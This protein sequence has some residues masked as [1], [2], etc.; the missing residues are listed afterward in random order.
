[1]QS[2][3]SL[4]FQKFEFNASVYYLVREI[5]F[6]VKGYNIIQVAGS[7]LAVFTF[8]AILL[9]A[10]YSHRSMS[11]AKAML[12]ALVIYLFMATTV[13]PW[14][15]TP[16]VALV[17]FTNYKFPVVWSMA[18]ILSYAGYSQ[19]GYTENIYL[20]IAEYTVV[21]FTMIWDLTRES[22]RLNRNGLNMVSAS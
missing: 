9:F 15:V 3:L 22:D 11:W 21:V 19:A 6:A 13:H 17:V 10:Y 16:L 8:L 14:Y 7:Y 4:Y 12:W 18:V 5:G 20:V 2:S 1:M